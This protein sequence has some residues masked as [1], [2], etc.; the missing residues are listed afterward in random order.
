MADQP[1]A[2]GE[3]S[4]VGELDRQ[5]RLGEVLATYF[6]AVEAGSGLTPQELV[7][8][9]P[10]LAEELEGFFADQERFGRVV[11]PLRPVG[12]AA[13]AEGATLGGTESTSPSRA[14]IPRPAPTPSQSEG[15]GLIPDRNAATVDQ[16]K[17][18]GRVAAESLDTDTDLSRGTRV[19]YFG[20]YELRGVLGKGGMGV[21]YKAKQLSLNRLVALKM[22]RAGT[23]A[24]D[25]E[26]RRFRNEAEA[27]ANLDHPQI[28][29]IHEVGRYDGQHYFSMKLVDGPSLAEHL[30][31]YAADPR[32]AARLV[33]DVARAVHH[34]HQRGIL[35]RDLKP[36]NIVLD[37]EGRPHVTDFGL[38]KRIE[39][40]GSLS[41]SGAILGTPSYMS[42]EQASG[43]KGTITTA[44][45]IY[46]LGAILYAAL[47]GRPPF[48][49]DSV[50]ETL[51]QV[52]ERAP[53]RPGLMNRRVDRDLET[54]CLKCLEKDPRRR[55]DSAAA[56]A[57][58]L[59]RYLRG[60]PILAR[61]VGTWVRT[62]KWTRRR[63][64]S[65]ALAAV[66]GIA[67][68]TLVGLGVALSYQSRLKAAYTEKD[69]ALARELTFLYQN[70]VLFAERELNDN[71]VK[72]VE[73]LLDECPTSLRGWEWRYLKRQCHLELMTLPGHVGAV[74]PVATSR[75][76]RW[77][78]SGGE[79]KTVRIWAAE[80]GQP[81]RIL[82]GHNQPVYSVAFSPDSSRLASVGGAFTELGRLLVHEVE[83]GVPVLNLPLDTGFLSSVAYRPDGRYLAVASGQ[84]SPNAWVRIIDA[85]TGREQRK[86]PIPAGETAASS[87]SY[88]PDG[89]RLLAV[90]GLAMYDDPEY[91]PNQVV[92]WDLASG[93]IEHRLHGHAAPAMVAV[94][95][96]DGRRIAAA[97]YDATVRIWHAAEGREFATCRGHRGC[98]NSVAFSPDGLRI[99]STCDD[100]SAKVWNVETGA[101]LLHLRGHR[102]PIWGVVFS[103]DGQRLFTSAMDGDVKVFDA[104]TSREAVTL[105]AHPGRANGVLFS[106]DGRWL[107]SYGMDR[108]LR[109]WDWSTG[110]LRDTWT[111]HSDP[112]WRVAF[113]PDGRLLASAAGDWRSDN[114]PGEIIIRDADNGRVLHTL[115]AHRGI[116]RAVAFSPD[117]RLLATGGGENRT[118]N[119]DVILWDLA[120]FLERRSFR[121][122][123][124]GVTSVAFTPDGQRIIASAGKTIRAWEVETGRPGI[125]FAG[126]EDVISQLAL[127][128]NGRWIVSGSDDNVLKVW[129]ARSG[130][131][132][133]HLIG[134]TYNSATLVISPDSSRIAAASYDE[135]ARIWD[136]ATGQNLI[137]LRGHRTYVLGI[138]FSPDGR[139][140]ASCDQNGLV[141]LWDGSPVVGGTR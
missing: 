52:R 115:K 78:A 135:T 86:L 116:A 107:V 27:V 81:V 46:G 98:I 41:A 13:R 28:V 106:P 103:A 11:A 112:I 74:W 119:Q 70:R 111:E 4:E 122:L 128:P 38:A 87:A 29:T 138:A 134:P 45:D 72:A 109:I 76:G 36:S 58:D 42:P 65:A 96:P 6:A 79:D 47:T 51:E 84:R 3:S 114:R 32:S 71:N 10:E 95:S 101:E 118:P 110:R 40:G 67:V 9:F 15:K 77:I 19:R 22:I 18:S 34:A 129:D 105:A 63:P 33:A 113:S 108:S 25:D 131:L 69:A 126:H 2:T 117:G 20:D 62:V 94:F 99:A 82:A 30:V 54:I 1:N 102:G 56:V 120:T 88:S 24:G 48:Q 132:V 104:T 7:A 123:P 53:E 21:V 89:T 73:Q 12:Q 17:D 92:V 16:T 127:S 140:V 141:K 130:R 83:T 35:H 124:G 39:G 133:R 55:Y 43:R 93:R 68:L 90:I 49:S 5:R 91:R 136:L 100:N 137:T 60:E 26:L 31:P 57:D 37:A 59:E 8:Q 85:E 139:L 50:V 125:A 64:A 80:T 75:D 23:W 14:E 61:R 66:S 121:N 97:G 44:V